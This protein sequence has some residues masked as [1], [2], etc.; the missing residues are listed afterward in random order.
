MKKRK[1]IISIQSLIIISLLILV[2]ILI[3]N[4]KEKDENETKIGSPGISIEEFEKIE[5][6]MTQ[7]DVNSIIDENDEWN[8]DDIYNKCCQ[9]INES[10]EDHIYNF[11][12]KYLGENDG[13]AIITYTCDY[14]NGSFFEYP[15]V[16]KK[17]N[18]NLK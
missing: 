3:I 10:N 11:T 2:L 13:Y 9:E 16:S 15:T 6:G 12:Y 4:N 14:S 17:E 18:H 8:D 5:L 7:F 1:I